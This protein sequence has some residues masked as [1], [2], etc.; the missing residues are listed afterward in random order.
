MRSDLLRVYKTVHTWTG[1]ACGMALFICFY[2]GALTM[3]KDDL[4]DWATPPVDPA[5]WIELGA[6]PAVIEQVLA[7]QPDAR[8]VLTLHLDAHRPEA[9]RARLSWPT[10]GGTQSASASLDAQGHLQVR[11]RQASD[12]AAFIDVLHMTAGI[13]GGF[14]IGM[15]VMGAVSLLYGLALVSGL[16]VLL[17]TLLKDLFVVRIGK[18]LKRM[19]LDAHNVVG[20]LSLPFHLVMALSVVGFGLHDY[21][22]AAQDRLIYRGQ[23][24]PLLQAQNPYYA[25][26]PAP[27][28]AAAAAGA[29]AGACANAATLR[30]PAQLLALARTV[31]PAVMTWRRAG[32]SGATVWIGGA[33]RGYL[34]RSGGFALMDAVTGRFINKSFLPGAGNGSRWAALSS[35]VYALHFGSYGGALVQWAYCLL[36]LAGAFLFYSGNLLWIESRRKSQRTPAPAQAETHAASEAMV[37]QRR[38]T[39][40]MAALTVG[41]AFGC[42]NGISLSLVAAKWLNAQVVQMHAW[43]AAIYYTVFLGCIGWACWR[44]A[45]RAA[46][47]LPRLASAA[48]AALALTSIAGWLLPATG[49]WAGSGSGCSAIDLA[50]TLGAAVFAWIARV[51]ARRAATGRPDSVWF[52]PRAQKSVVMDNQK[53]RGRP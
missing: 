26:A 14:A 2:A 53:V 18:N 50:A 32:Q 28:C 21:L 20:L 40:I 17:P 1:L 27:A 36:G 23:L 11:T 34:A 44:G 45:A 3:F 10:Q 33:D 42:I 12:V 29:A 46:V 41:V 52:D 47:E 13:P 4:A 38:S 37:V 22:Y 19:W 39:H 16:V 43:H 8:R 5:Q 30:T 48:A 31:E 7:T 25:S 9:R 35:A 6:A 15:G 49:E 24:A 51:A